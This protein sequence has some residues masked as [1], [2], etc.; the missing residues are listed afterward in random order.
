MN[1]KEILK[2][3]L[4]KTVFRLNP[5]SEQAIISAMEEHK[6]IESDY[7]AAARAIAVWLKPFCNEELTYPN[8]IAGAAR[9]AAIYITQLEE[10]IKELEGML[11]DCERAMGDVQ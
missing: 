11:S 9:E 3:H 10:R 1:A 6:A 4:D 7:P 5:I 2:K 8:M